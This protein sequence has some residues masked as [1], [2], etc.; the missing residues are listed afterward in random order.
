MKQVLGIGLVGYKFMGKAH[1]NAYAKLGMFFDTTNEIKKVAI[2]G[3]DPEWVKESRDKF[4]WQHCE[5]DW[6]RLV[7]RDDIDV[8]DITTPSNFHTEIGL[9][10]AENKKHIFCEKPLALNTENARKMLEAAERNGV[11][12]QVGF[13][14]RFAPAILL[15]KRLIDAGKIGK[16]YHFRGNYLQDFLVDENFP[17]IWRLDKS[18]AGSGSLGDLGAHVI[19]LARF[20]VGEITEVSG[21][22]RTFVEKRP[23]VERMTGLSGN[24]SADAEMGAVTVDDATSFVCAFD[25]GAMGVFEATRFAAGH[26]NALNFEINGSEGSIRFN[27][28]RLNELEYFSRADDDGTQGFRSINVTEGSH[29]YMEHWWPAGHI[30]GYEHTFVHE[31]Y[32]FTEAIA[33]DR[34]TSPDFRD[35]LKCCEILDAVET[36]AAERCWVKVGM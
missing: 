14:Y 34:P 20:L 12:H 21:M 32:E 4:G 3:R 13:N 5:T 33:N 9:A 7:K 31:L 26:K 16:V 24:A 15:A 19:D 25:C 8:I 2:C 1:S 6:Q 27:L 29:P 10:A 36:S 18:V 22:A 30:I 35:G 11:K 28:E 17:L 23:I